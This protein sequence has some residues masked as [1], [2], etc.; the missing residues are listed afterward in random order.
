MRARSS[1]EI[2]KTHLAG[3]PHGG[4]DGG[5]AR[6]HRETRKS[7][8]QQPEVPQ[9]VLALTKGR[10]QPSAINCKRFAEGRD[11]SGKD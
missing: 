6:V 1:A 8:R 10:R 7:C 2:L 11:R 9:K 3:N 5:A 4:G